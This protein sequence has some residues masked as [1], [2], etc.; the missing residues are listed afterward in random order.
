[1][2][3][4][5]AAA[6]W[7]GWLLAGLYLGHAAEEAAQGPRVLGICLEQAGAAGAAWARGGEVPAAP[8]ATFRLR[9]FGSGFANSSWSWAAPEGAGCPEGGPAAAT[10]TGE[11]RTLLRLR[12]ET[13]HPHS[14]LLAVRGEPGGAADEK[15]AAAAAAPAGEWRAL[16]RLRAE[17]VRTEPSVGAVFQ[18]AG[19]PW[20][21]GLGAAGLL[22]LAAL[23]R[24]L[25]LTALVLAPAEV[26]VLRENGSE[27][28]RAAARRLE[29]ARRWASCALGALLL[30]ASLAQA[31]L[32]VLLY[33]AAG[34]RALPAVLGSAGLA[35]VVAEVLPAAVSG[36]WTLAL[37][38]RALVLSRL[39]VLLTLPVALPVGQLL[40]LAA[41]P[42]RL[43]E[44]V[45]ELARGSGDPYSDL[46]KG[47]LR[48]RTV[49]EV[50]TPL[51]DCFMLDASTV[52]D[53]GVLASIMQS[54]HTRIPVYEEERSNIVDMLYLKDL[55]FV[56]PEDCTPLSTITRFYNH[57]LHFVFNDT[58]LDAVLEEFKRGKSHLAIVQKVNNEGEGDPFYEVLGLIT[59]EDVI[60]EVIKSEIL[61]ESEDYRDTTVRKKP[62]SL[63]APLR[64]KEEF[65]LFKVSDDEYK[66]KISPQL[67]LATQRFLSREVDVFSPLRISEKVL[68]HLLRHPSVNQ[69]VRFDE[70]NRLAA[71]H[72]LYQ[73]SQP[74]DYF[75][76]IL[77]GRVEVEIGK[78][79]LKFE[80]GAFTYYGVS[81]LTAPSS[82]HQSPVSSLQSL[83]HDLQPEP[84]D[85]TRLST[86]RPDYT[87]RALS[88]LQFIKVTRLQ[89]LNALLATRA[90]N[91][92]PSPDN[93]DLQVI[94][95][96]QTRLLSDRTVTAA[97][98]NHD[99]PGLPA[100]ES[101]GRN[102]GV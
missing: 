81:A 59:L 86:Y 85:G 92:P 89:Y 67:L 28:E 64:R 12:A 41:R 56:D 82:V 23:A 34:Q 44:R 15:T 7:L 19:P 54:G 4:A 73:R 21:L 27:A 31:A 35:F 100:E 26:Q 77:Q 101:P 43:R 78:E 60:E 49:E 87:V 66:V 93:L 79:G 24:G 37:A 72:Y 47:V 102:P 25:Q 33:R 16:L 40:E 80:N 62:A 42:G 95:G 17:A 48:Y 88:D 10:L 98:S 9:L 30:L 53:F 52:L 36:R 11:W 55:A 2:A 71:H 38:P 32:A 6:G 74:V 65:S 39:A 13:E 97:A 69:E 46:S 84:A 61:D 91:L 22:A 58:K 99:R 3:A 20:A 94:P 83:R 14:A 68:L 29:P 50:L 18:E 45:L 75:I 90:Q 57:P 96:S 63:S 70:S 51:E 76:L 8:E 5:A 1:M